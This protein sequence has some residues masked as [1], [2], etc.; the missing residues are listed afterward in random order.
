MA[1]KF[2]PQRQYLINRICV[3]LFG[4]CVVI[5]G[6]CVSHI[7]G[8]LDNY[9]TRAHYS[10]E[11][12]GMNARYDYGRFKDRSLA[13]NSGICAFASYH[14]LYIR[15]QSLNGSQNFH[16]VDIGFQIEKLK[17]REK[18]FPKGYGEIQFRY[19]SG[20]LQIGYQ[21]RSFGQPVNIY[22]YILYSFE[23][24]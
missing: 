7:P 18:R 20:Q 17:E 5:I 12:K 2:S 10:E 23:M 9:C 19:I 16:S 14:V 4:M 6:G 8:G 11:L 22:N 3:L 24:N 13:A 15:W 21:I 1:T